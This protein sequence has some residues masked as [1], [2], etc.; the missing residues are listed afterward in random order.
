L[1]AHSVL[2]VLLALTAAVTAQDAVPKELA[3]LQG[4][5]IVTSVNGETVD[6]SAQAVFRITG[7]QYMVGQG[8]K[9]V[10]RGTVKVD[11]SKKP[12]ALDFII[13]AGRYQ[14]LT[15][16]GILEITSDT[17]KLYVNTP[18]ATARPTDF[19]RRDG[20]DLVIA[21]KSPGGPEFESRRPDQFYDL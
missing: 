16:L 15:Q 19:E 9:L 4:R 8:G 18:G 13:S 3:P 7:D 20:H 21:K 17:L 2:T 5:W 14:G 1:K 6:S 12:M 11:A 10:E